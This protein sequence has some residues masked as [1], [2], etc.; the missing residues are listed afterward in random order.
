MKSQAKFNS[1][2][3]TNDGFL[4]FSAPLKGGWQVSTKHVLSAHRD[5]LTTY[6]GVDAMGRPLR[7]LPESM[8]RFV[9]YLVHRLE[10]PVI[11]K[12]T[13][14]APVVNLQGWVHRKLS[15]SDRDEVTSCALTAWGEMPASAQIVA[16]YCPLFRP[17]QSIAIAAFQL[18]RKALEMGESSTSRRLASFSLDEHYDDN[19]GAP[20]IA[21]K[22]VRSIASGKPILTGGELR[23]IDSPVRDA[24]A[25]KARTLRAMARLAFHRDE[26][27]KRSH[28]YKEAHRSL[29]TLV[30]MMNGA[31][32]GDVADM[33]DSARSHKWERLISYLSTGIE[34][35]SHSPRDWKGAS[36][37]TRQCK[38]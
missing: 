3:P 5:G 19:E 34:D 28:N 15:P 27:R 31:G 8:Q 33:S 14:A 4:A 17:P 11:K 21:S 1:H 6:K 20:Q 26:S 35:G 13:R 10:T 9:S 16:N 36:A 37:W 25:K 22:A 32:M 29:R 12:K 30:S 2:N 24:I 38:A 23:S 18:A 7:A